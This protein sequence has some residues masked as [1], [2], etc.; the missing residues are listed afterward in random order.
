MSSVIGQAET[1]KA[2]VATGAPPVRSVPMSP[3]TE[4]QIRSAFVNLT[5]GEAKRANLPTDLAATHWDDL[6]YLGWRDP[7]SPQRAYLVTEHAG[8]LRAI[9]MRLATPTSGPR[10]TMCS[11]C[12]TVG[13]VSLMAAPR[14]GRSGQAGN[15][16]GTYICTELVCSL[17]ARDKLRPRGEIARETLAVE[18][19]IE[20]LR[21]NLD[22]FV[23]RVLKPV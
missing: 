21:D 13:D 19:K 8:V 11:L 16:V 20:R 2:V 1:S 3:V 18:Q 5:G 14:A 9:G 22:S 12:M 15:T 7:K 6:D 4:A 10:K 23:A 17:Y